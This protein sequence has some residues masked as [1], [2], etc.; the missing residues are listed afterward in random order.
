MEDNH[1]VGPSR[2]TETEIPGLDADTIN[3]L[4][5]MIQNNIKS[6]FASLKRNFESQSEETAKQAAKRLKQDLEI[7]FKYK[8]NKEQ[9]QF[10]NDI[11]EGLLRVE[12]LVQ[13]G[14]QDEALASIEPLLEQLKT[15]Q[16]HIRMADRSEGGWTTVEEFK[17]DELAED[18]EEERKMRRSEGRAIQKIKRKRQET[19]TFGRRP[20]SATYTPTAANFMQTGNN[21]SQPFRQ[22]FQGT[23]GGY[24]R[25]RTAGP[26]DV[27][28]KCGGISHWRKD[29]P[30][31]G[32]GGPGNHGQG[33]RH[34]GKSGFQ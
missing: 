2:N 20:P 28:F 17:K 34:T 30:L 7:D 31:R 15:R 1:E 10:N 4:G 11:S 6:E 21:T 8:S 18:S 14:R 23:P 16:K 5:T 9:F 32:G 33:P 13:G 22:P 24:S 12:K 27:C 3:L 19:K 26:Y 25:P 29:C